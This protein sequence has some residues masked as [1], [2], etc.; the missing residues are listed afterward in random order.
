MYHLAHSFLKV[1]LS[2]DALNLDLF[3]FLHR[4]IL[5]NKTLNFLV[6]LFLA[7]KHVFFLLR[8]ASNVGIVVFLPLVYLLHV[9]VQYFG[10]S[11]SELLSLLLQMSLLLLSLFQILCQN[12]WLVVKSLLMLANNLGDLVQLVVEAVTRCCIGAMKERIIV[13]VQSSSLTLSIPGR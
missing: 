10:L 3:L 12:L 8:K 13:L 4:L 9:Q 1:N 6:D 11:L 7:L 2:L 5:L